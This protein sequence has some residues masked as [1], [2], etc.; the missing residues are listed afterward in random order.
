MSVTAD[1][2]RFAHFEISR[3]QRKLWRAGS[4]VPLGTRAFDILLALI[5]RRDRVVAASELLDIVWPDVVVEENNLRVHICALRKHV[6]ASA[7]VTIPGRGYRFTAPLYS[8][9]P[10]PATRSK[11]ATGSQAARRRPPTNLPERL[12]PLYGRADELQEL[13]SM[14]L[15]HRLVTL[16]GPGGV[17]KTRLARAAA[18]DLRG[19]WPD[20]VWLVELAAVTDPSL[21]PITIAHAVGFKS[22]GGPEPSSRWVAGLSGRILLVLLDDCE[23]VIDAVT[24]WV[25]QL[26]MHVSDGRVLVTSQRPLHLAEEQQYRVLPLAVPQSS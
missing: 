4:L 25:A 17:G 2:I 9:S 8:G 20:G 14:L 11:V 7:I 1:D 23:H 13:G 26:L 15:A 5:D 19:Q 18:H 3:S 10:L 22:Y 21:V 12:P 6:G 16:V 24:A